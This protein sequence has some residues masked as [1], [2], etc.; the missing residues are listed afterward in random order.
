MAVPPL[1]VTGS[2][3]LEAGNWKLE[4]GIWQLAVRFVQGREHPERVGGSPPPTVY[5]QLKDAVHGVDPA[6]ALRMLRF[7]A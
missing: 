1:L 7:C 4:T 2:W 6:T 5:R 3:K